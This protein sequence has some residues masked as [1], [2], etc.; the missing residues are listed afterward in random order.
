MAL[1]IILKVKKGR[2]IGSIFMLDAHEGKN[3]GFLP[4]DRDK[5]NS[6]TQQN[7]VFQYKN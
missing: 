1:K 7:K 2:L 4:A 5:K 3:V 6:T